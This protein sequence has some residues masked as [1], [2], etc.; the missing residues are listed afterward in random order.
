MSLSNFE[1]VFNEFNLAFGVTNNNIPQPKLYDENPGL[2]KYRLSLIEEEVQELNDA[3]KNKDFK[4]TI[5]AL[6]DILY[7]VYGAYSAFGVNAD[8]A[9]DLVHNSN[10]SK[11]CNSEQEAIETVEFYKKDGRYDS[12]N[13]RLSPDGNYYVV[14]NESTSKI[15]KSIN[16]KPV[17][18]DSLF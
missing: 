8:E 6:T 15:L 11:L 18:F 17:S 14:Y 5:D 7:V 9:F 16:Y 12:P 3:I 13:Y 4:E 10:M 1:K 2:V